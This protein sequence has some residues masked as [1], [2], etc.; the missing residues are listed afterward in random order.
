MNPGDV[1]RTVCSYNG[2]SDLLWGL[3]SQEEMCISFMYYYPRVVTSNKFPITCGVG[4]EA[5]LPG[6]GVTYNTTQD[7]ETFTQ[8]DRLFGGVP[9]SCPYIA[10]LPNAAAPNR[11]PVVQ[12]VVTSPPAATSSAIFSMTTFSFVVG[13]MQCFTIVLTATVV[14]RIC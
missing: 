10:A 11:S 6:C 9:A 7:F 3:A 5:F 4:V 2:S 8:L 14:W 1:F 13:S 12:Q